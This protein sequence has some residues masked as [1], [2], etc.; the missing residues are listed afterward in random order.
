MAGPGIVD[1]DVGV[2][3][4]L[5]D[6]LFGVE[7]AEAGGSFR[8][9]TAE[10]LRRK[11]P[12]A[13][14]EGVEELAPVLRPGEPRGDGGEVLG[15]GLLLPEGE[16]AVAAGHGLDAVPAE[17]LP[18]GFLL[19]PVPEGRGADIAAGVFPLVVDAVIQ[20]EVLGA[21]GGVGALAP[22]AGP[23]QLQEGFPAGDGAED[24]RG[25]R[26]LGEVEEA[27][28]GLGLRRLGM[29]HGIAGGAGLAGGQALP[30]HGG[31][32]G[33]VLTVE[34][35]DAAQAL[36]VLEG[37]VQGPVVQGM[38]PVQVEAEGGDTGGEDLR[39]LGSNGLVPA[40]E[41]HVEAVVTVGAA[42]GLPLA[43]AQGVR[44]GLVPLGAGEVHHR[45]GAAPEGGAGAGGEVIRR[46]GLAAGTEVGPA[47]HKAGEEQAAGDIHRL[48]GAGEPPAHLEDLLPLQQDIQ[49]AGAVGVHDSAAPQQR[50]HG[51]LPP[52]RAL[53]ASPA[54]RAGASNIPRS[55]VARENGDFQWGRRKKPRNLVG[56][57]G[58][59]FWGDGVGAAEG[60]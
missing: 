36:E 17:G 43:A 26:R 30:L 32:E 42:V 56:F 27:A 10:V 41:G 29:G 24:H 12:G 5:E 35:G 52:F 55:I 25:V 47:I 7:A 19:A 48:V 6:A 44:K 13:D 3:A 9:D 16:G 20:E 23:L 18:E 8:E 58:G 57:S 51:D 4:G 2:A 50:F 40:G 14:A 31:D 15:V 53:G 28:H 60:L 22:L 37:Q 49:A 11:A 59:D 39:Q 1:H 54:R 34:G 46:G 45:G 21:G 38:G 33:A